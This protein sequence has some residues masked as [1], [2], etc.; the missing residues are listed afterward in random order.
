MH[1]RN[2]RSVR[3]PNLIKIGRIA[4]DHNRMR[5]CKHEINESG[6]MRRKENIRVVEQ[7]N[8]LHE[9]QL[10]H[11]GVRH[12]QILEWEATLPI[13][14]ESVKKKCQP[15]RSASPVRA[16][17]FDRWSKMGFDSLGFLWI[18][19]LPID[20]RTLSSNPERKSPRITLHLG[21]I[22][23]DQAK[24]ITKTPNKQA[25][26]ERKQTTLFNVIFLAMWSLGVKSEGKRRNSNFK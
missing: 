25:T 20:T 19:W 18:E 21:C 5:P 3:I 4:F 14:Q 10:L 1:T 2:Q 16:F 8:L 9:R 17:H 13:K 23:N 26:A 24:S 12:I 7:S 11:C 15:I 6:A 22:G